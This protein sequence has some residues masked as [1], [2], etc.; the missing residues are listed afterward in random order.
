MSESAELLTCST[1]KLDKPKNK[2]YKNRSR[3]RGYGYQCKTCKGAL[4]KK[5]YSKEKQKSYKHLKRYGINKDGYNTMF[6]KQQGCCAICNTHQSNLKRSLAVDHC[7]ETGKI[8]GLLC[9]NCNIG[10]GNFK[11]SLVNLNMAVFYLSKGE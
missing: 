10:L 1:C 4:D 9:T 11:D 8:R 3:S 5:I 7:H 6:E 2:F